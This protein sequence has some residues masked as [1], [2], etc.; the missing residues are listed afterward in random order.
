MIIGREYE[1][2]KLLKILNSTQGELVAVYGRRR[3]G[4]TY[5]I[6]E[7]FEEKQN[8]K[9]CIFFRSNGTLNGKLNV[10]LAKFKEEIE[11]T[12]YSAKAKIK[13][14][15]FKNWHEAFQ[16]LYDAINLF[17]EKQKVVIFLDEF[18]WMATPRS[19]LLGALDY[20]WNRFWCQDQR[21]KVIVCGSA[22]SWMIHNIIH[23]TGGLHNRVTLKLSLAPFTLL[24]TQEYLKTRKVNYNQEQVLILYMCLGGIP[25]YL[26]FVEKGLSAIQ[27]VSNACFKNNGTLYDEFKILFKSLFKNYESHEE[28]I[29]FIAS[30]REGVSRKTIESKFENKGGR[31]TERLEELEE[32]GFICSFVPWKKERGRYYKVIDE[33]S[34]F[35]LTW[36]EPHAKS[37]IARNIDEHY[38]EILSQKPA[39]NAW[40]GLAFEAICYKHIQ[41]IRKS[42]S[43]PSGSE[44]TTWRYVPTEDNEKG[45]Q[46]D[47][48]FE[49]PDNIVNLCE[50][51]YT[52]EPFLIDKQYAAHLRYR[53]QIYIQKTQTKKQIFHSFITSVGIKNNIY[54]K[55]MVE[56]VLTLSELFKF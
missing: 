19:D 56:S 43:I 16:A 24:E 53:E 13:L 44:V 10:Q 7:F 39:W 36:I 41:Q 28:I 46:I 18:P 23:N 38:W 17:A 26:N 1:Q 32:A 52:K 20:F 48:I 50:I 34:L 9:S 11:R 55:D 37:R 45:V 54:S 14:A 42:L 12:F 30:F 6:R 4:K 47:L 33:Y 8:K 15:Q 22:A 21:I 40:S 3:V 51:K 2:E 35:Y 27:N 29:R 31:L 5:L 25:H 49:R